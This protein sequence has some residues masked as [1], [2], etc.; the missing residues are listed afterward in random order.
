[1]KVKIVEGLKA[2]FPGVSNSIINRITEKILETAKTEEEGEEAVEAMT[3]QQAIDANG[4]SRATEAA[5][6]AY[7]KYEKKYG[8]KDGKPISTG[9]DNK[10]DQETENEK[11]K[12]KEK[13]KTGNDDQQEPAWAK[14]QREKM[15]ALEARLA[16]IDGDKIASTRKKQLVAAMGKAP[17]KLRARYEKDLTRMNFK[18]DSEYSEWLEEVKTDMEA[19]VAE[20]AVKGVTFGRPPSAGGPKGEDKPSPE[21]AARI[22]LREAETAAPAILGL[23]TGK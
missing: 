21:V 9:D 8:L 14:A 5:N 12:D 15:E 11:E 1:M 7:A 17:E 20:A 16:A 4:D 19:F 2:K 10:S 3:F 13:T 18:D 22:K 23:P 6:T